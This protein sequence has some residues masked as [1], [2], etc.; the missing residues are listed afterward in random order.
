[1]RRALPAP[2]AIRVPS[3]CRTAHN[4]LAKWFMLTRETIRSAAYAWWSAPV[5][6]TLAGA[7]SA[8]A[9]ARAL[10]S[11]GLVSNVALILGVAGADPVEGP[12][13]DVAG[14]HGP[15]LLRPPD[16]V[17]AL[18]RPDVECPTR[19]EVDDLVDE[20]AVRVA[21]PHPL[22]AV[23]VVPVGLVRR[24]PAGG[25]HVLLGEVEADPGAH[26]APIG[27][28]LEHLVARIGDVARGVQPLHRGGS[29]GIGLHALA[30]AAGVRRG[31]EPE[32]DERF[33]ADPEA[34]SHGDGVAF[35]W[36]IASVNAFFSGVVK[37]RHA[38]FTSENWI[39]KVTSPLR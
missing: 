6:W 22:A 27:S 21:A 28:R 26:P 9:T 38:S 32:P 10:A 5:D 31:S 30:E 33:D 29:V 2:M 20:G 14:R 17:A 8:P 7:T 18:P 39:M 1:M 36:R 25:P 15:A 3:G 23:A 16:R 24:G 35:R 11:D 19:F 12:P 13:G 37:P 34:R 4:R